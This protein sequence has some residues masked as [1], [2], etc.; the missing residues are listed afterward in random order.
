MVQFR[1]HPKSIFMVVVHALNESFF[2][3]RELKWL[4]GLNQAFE[5]FKAGITQTVILGLGQKNPGCF[6]NGNCGA[7]AV[8]YIVGLTHE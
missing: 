1:K 8:A 5:M 3:S 6:R 4:S 2:L 7:S